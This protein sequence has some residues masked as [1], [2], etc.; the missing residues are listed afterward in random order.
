MKKPS[1]IFDT[2]E[3]TGFARV[4]RKEIVDDWNKQALSLAEVHK[5]ELG[6]LVTHNAIIE[7]KVAEFDKHFKAYWEL[8]KTNCSEVQT[9]IEASNREKI[10]LYEQ[11]RL[12]NWLRT[13]LTE[14]DQKAEAR[15]YEEGRKSVVEEAS[16]IVEE[17]M[18]DHEHWKAI[19]ERIKALSHLKTVKTPQC[20][21]QSYSEDGV[22]KDCTCG[23]CRIFR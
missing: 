5:V 23:K 2:P 20:F 9:V 11:Q 7:E 18:E 6:N 17:M 8:P 1:E 10:A 19:V 21:C 4:K 22:V 3:A 12:T 15:G 14:V 13:T 16:K